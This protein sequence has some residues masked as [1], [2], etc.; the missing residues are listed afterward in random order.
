MSQ[1]LITV[2]IYHRYELLGLK[3]YLVLLTLKK[4]NSILS[5]VCSD[6]RRGLD[7]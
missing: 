6:N 3:F 5:H 7:W 4:K 1:E 2:L